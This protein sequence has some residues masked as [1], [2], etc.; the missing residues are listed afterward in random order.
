MAVEVF[1]SIVQ[2]ILL[3]SALVLFVLALHVKDLVRGIAAFAAGSA[4]VAAGF[5]VLAAPFA[6]VLELTVGAGLMA[7][8]FLVAVSLTGHT[9]DAEVSS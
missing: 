4:L 5:F 8:L 6:G 1:P 3:G 7:V 9:D 2:A